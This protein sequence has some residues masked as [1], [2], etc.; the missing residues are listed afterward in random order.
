MIILVTALFVG[1]DTP[2]GTI[3]LGLA[4]LLF[5]AVIVLLLIGVVYG[6]V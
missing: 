5:E 1:K 6:G 3:M 2:G 4:E